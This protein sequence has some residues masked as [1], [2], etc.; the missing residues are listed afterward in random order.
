VGT[1]LQPGDPSRIGPY[2]LLEVLGN[3]GMGRVYLGRSPGG[4]QVAVKVIRAQLATDPEFRT[5]FRREVAA[6]RMVNG[7]YTAA[8]VDA[9][10]EGQ[11]PWLATAYINGPSLADAVQQGGPLPPDAL[12]PFAAALA[13]GLSA[14]HAAGLVHRDL[15]PSNVLLAPDGPRVIDFGI[16]YAAEATSLTE[17][18]VVIGSPGYLSPE[19]AEA[20][21][22]VAA[23][24]D[25]F[26]LGSVLCY[27]ATGHSPWGTGSSAALLYRVVHAEPGIADVP[28]EI[29][30][31]VA[32]CLA[33]SPGQRPSAAGI[34]A[35][36]GDPVPT[37]G[38][39]TGSA[40]DTASMPAPANQG[41]AAGQPGVAAPGPP[42][43]PTQEVLI[44]RPGPGSAAAP[45]EPP[46]APG[47]PPA[48][49]R[50]RRAGWLAAAAVGA[51]AVI[52]VLLVTQ[53]LPDQGHGTGPSTPPSSPP[54][55]VGVY[56]GTGYA[57]NG[58]N[59][60][61]ADGSYAWVLNG[62]NDTVTQL[63]AAT[64]APVRI[65]SAAG[66]GFYLT[67]YDTPTGIIDDGTHVWVGNHDS[68]TEISAATGALVRQVEPP[69]SA[70][71]KGWQTA[72]ARAGSQLW[73]AL[74]DTCRPYCT[75]SPG[76]GFFATLIEYDASTGRYLRA[77]TQ[78]TTQVP[79]AVTADG[80]SSWLVGGGFG[81]GH[82]N[83]SVTE[84]SSSAGR[85]EWSVPVT[86]VTD[87]AGTPQLS[88]SYDDGR[89]WIAN[90]ETVTE[91]NASNGRQLKVLPGAR[92]KFS[93]P[94]IVVAAG[95]H[96]LVANLG[97][98]SVSEINASTGALENTLSAA[99]YHFN[100]LAGMA[101]TGNRVWVLN[102]GS[103]GSVVELSL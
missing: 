3:G 19:Q 31:L 75:G 87:P 51:A 63:S 53:A 22:E 41:T 91:L 76:S 42:R 69:A 27:A 72:L 16:A 70:N 29:R 14:V 71:Y 90:G 54:S 66:Y 44:V 89:L 67:N 62:G 57:F 47:R 33:K 86:V 55:L 82:D 56:S 96:V 52:V 37:G 84:F 25:V 40:P 103:P 18:N 78:D 38:W 83:G 45:E 8:V 74:P 99:R 58:P 1:E 94:A 64:G 12:S 68:V 102:S 17:T 48:R 79:I 97:G 60:I 50:R 93:Q 39:P 95:T 49:G 34:L 26:S 21:R 46:A 30:S 5:R 65:L 80:T 32:R 13:E 36:L 4:R 11:V 98:D 9:D 92:Y 7:I 6:A 73:A 59:A 101:V 20:D 28:D 24:S 15:K 85:Q 81:A 61:A 43:S 2:R 23:A 100:G 77:I 35:E 88:V 10:T